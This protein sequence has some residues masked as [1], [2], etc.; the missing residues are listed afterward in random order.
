M[1]HLRQKIDN[2]FR[3]RASMVNAQGDEYGPMAEI[4]GIVA[5]TPSKVRG[6]RTERLILEE[7]G[8]NKN[9]ITS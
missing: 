8:S 1:K 4:E 2:M 5:D 7:G 6:D 3:K 9:L